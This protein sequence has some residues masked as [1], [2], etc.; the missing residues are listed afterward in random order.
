MLGLCPLV[1]DYW[2]SKS[3]LRGRLSPEHSCHVARFG[4]RYCFSFKSGAS[5]TTGSNWHAR[6]ASWKSNEE[7]GRWVRLTWLCAVRSVIDKWRQFPWAKYGSLVGVILCRRHRLCTLNGFATGSD[8]RISEGNIFAGSSDRRLHT[9]YIHT[10]TYI[11]TC[12]HLDVLRRL[13]GCT[14]SF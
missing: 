4:I 13:R 6:C 12:I 14:Q 10:Y 11:H 9:T 8:E 2:N 7:K 1:L 5:A 3:R